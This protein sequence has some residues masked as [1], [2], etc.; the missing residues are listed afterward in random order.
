MSN[1]LKKASAFDMAFQYST[2]ASIIT[3]MQGILV[4]MN[5]PYAE[6]LGYAPDEARQ[7]TTIDLIPPGLIKQEKAELAQLQNNSTSHITYNSQRIH[8][9]GKTVNVKV[10][11]IAVHSDETDHP[12]RILQQLEIAYNGNNSE[13]KTYSKEFYLE[14]IM[15]E[16]PAY[17]Y[18]KDLES[19]FLMASRSMLR[20]FGVKHQSELIGK[21]D[22]DFF[23]REH[24]QQAFNDEQEILRTGK[25]IIQVEKEVWPN[26]RI[27]WVH[28][29]K[30]PLYNNNG[31]LI[32]TF[33]ISKDITDL[34]DAEKAIEKA[35]FELE[36]KNSE[37]EEMVADLRATQSQLINTEKLAALGQLIAGIA[38]EV[39]TPL[40]AINASNSNIKTSFTQLIDNVEQNLTLFSPE[41]MELLKLLLNNYTGY[42]N[43]TLGS[44]EKRQLKK[45]IEQKINGSGNGNGNAIADIIVYLNQQDQLE[46]IIAY[47]DKTDALKVL[48]SAKNMISVLKN[49]ENI[50]IA[51][52]KASQVVSALKKYIHRTPDGKKSHTDIIDNIETVVTLNYNKLKHGVEIFRNYDKVPF[53]YVYPDEISQV[54]NNLITNAIHA[55]NNKGELHIS[56]KDKSDTI[57]VEFRDTGSGIPDDIRDMIFMPFFTTKASG[58][59]TGIGLDI[60]KRIVEKH[61]GIITIDTEINKGTTFSIE[62]P[63]N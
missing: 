55:M 42:T 40:G 41:E 56:V 19:R 22:F 44:R 58:E 49:S 43:H 60:V 51:T 16:M 63:K 15:A 35:H 47:L 33:G 53:I 21:T 18:F 3:D 52:E 37:L 5:K 4:R 10:N 30:K 45:E 54:W 38:H 7:L 6:L 32:G 26:G 13:A 14:K 59:G 12:D 46:T 23:A 20:L 61:N 62:L 50:A 2:T 1:T 17:I 29:T 27:T 25:E 9:S 11:A 57:I 24:A 28:T 31:T 36:W 48:K 8:K 34:K 39:N